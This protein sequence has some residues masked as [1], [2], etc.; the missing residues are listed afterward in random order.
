MSRFVTGFLLMV[1]L[2]AGACQQTSPGGPRV[3][4]PSPSAP[5]VL[6]APRALREGGFEVV[7]A[8]SP[9]PTTVSPAHPTNMP[10]PRPE[11][12][13]NVVVPEPY[14][15]LYRV[16]AEVWGEARLLRRIRIPRIGVDVLVVPVGW[17]I[18][19]DGVVWESPGPYVGWA[20]NSALPGA[21]GQILLY[22][23]NNIEGSV[24]RDLYQLQPGDTVVLTTPSGEWTYRVF[25]TQI[26]AV[27]DARTE[28]F[29]YQT[30][31]LPY[32]R[33]TRL[34]LISCYPPD[35]NTHRVLIFAH[36]VS[37]PVP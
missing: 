10:N 32:E 8:A 21:P 13:G 5:S 18:T 22:G 30:S 23:H 2:F 27:S 11:V 31:I 14:A 4:T 26:V 12:R 16:A 33:E 29:L 25:E 19:E 20:V 35:N 9:T 34:V 17:R 24:F 15:E 28:R 36:P 37:R 1:V 7:L 3:V 6:M